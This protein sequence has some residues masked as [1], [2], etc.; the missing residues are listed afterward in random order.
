MGLLREPKDI[1]LIIKS[2]PWTEAELV[3]FRIL[4]KKLKENKKK[5]P[6]EPAS[7]RKSKN[8]A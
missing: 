5:L 4:M 3:E 1:D 7:K 6:E 2:Q 8:Y